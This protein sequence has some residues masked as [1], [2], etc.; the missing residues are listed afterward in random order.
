M[1][2]LLTLQKCFTP[3]ASFFTLLR[4]CVACNTKRF[5]AVILVLTSASNA[6]SF[7]IAIPVFLRLRVAQK[8]L[9]LIF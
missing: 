8:A 9:Q 5:A 4:L 2:K 6:K 1:H 7:A 3:L